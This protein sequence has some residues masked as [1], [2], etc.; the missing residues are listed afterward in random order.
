MIGVLDWGLSLQEAIDLP[1]IVA[2]GRS[3][4]VE[5]SRAAPDLIDGLRAYGYDVQES[6]GET[7]GLHMA[8]RR[9]DG[10]FEAAADPR[11]EGVARRP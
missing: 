8:L 4:R 11:R 10:S 1:N 5:R 2:R 6:A 7:S 3:V 9:A